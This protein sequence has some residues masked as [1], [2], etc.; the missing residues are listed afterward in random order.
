MK[1]QTYL[2]NILLAIFAGGIC[3]TMLLFD[4]LAPYVVVPH[5]SI[6]LLVLMTV[7]PLAVENY[8]GAPKKREWAGTLIMG[9]LTLTVLPICA[10][11]LG[12][13]SILRLFVCSAAVFCL[14]TV[15]YTSMSKRMAGGAKAKAAPAVN[16]LLLYLA[17]QFFQGI[18]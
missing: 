1:K 18:M 12:D 4:V 16:A 15:L 6:P 9:T 17:A 10:G 14:T 3:L 11:Q 5:L 8:I 2:L 7:V 13:V